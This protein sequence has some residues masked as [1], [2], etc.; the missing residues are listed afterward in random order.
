[1][2]DKRDYYE[3]LGINKDSSDKDI[4]KAYRKLA[5]KYHPDKNPDNSEAEELFKEVAEAYEVLSD[6]EKKLQYDQYGH[7]GP[8]NFGGFNTDEMFSE[9]DR[10][11]G[12][13]RR[14]HNY[15][16]KRGQDLRLNVSI[17]LEEIFNGV[18]KKFKYKRMETCTPCNGV[19]GTGISDCETCKGHGIVMQVQNTQFGMMQ[20]QM[21]CPTCNG[22]GKIIENK[23]KSC[24][25]VGL[26]SNEVIVDAVI[27]HGISDGDALAID[28]MG[29]G[30][31][32]GHYGRLIII[33]NEKKHDLYNRFGND[34]RLK[35]KLSYSDLVL[36]TKIEINT[37]EGG[38]IRVT[39]PE[40][41][42]VGDNLRIQNKGMKLSNSETRGDMIIE[43][44]IIIPTEIS[45][46]DKKLLKK[47][48]KNTK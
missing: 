24:S 9:F 30:I 15:R 37:I 47:L 35:A 22:D 10:M 36:G 34:L 46:E 45:E 25:G 44:E 39:I 12:G 48:K 13:N 17:S 27:P 28:N 32:D 42:N 38:N 11:F 3:I 29:H 5:I 26:N 14:R 33:I 41:S 31:K 19:G 16:V 8:Q 4:K 40:F 6:S 1:M 18:T 23:C 20:T 43:L 7:D 21:T 2:S